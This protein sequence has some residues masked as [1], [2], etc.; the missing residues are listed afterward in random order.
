MTVTSPRVSLSPEL[1]LVLCPELRA[2]PLMLVPLADFWSMIA[3]FPFLND[4][5]AW[6]LEM[7]ELSITKWATPSFLPMMRLLPYC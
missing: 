5:M 7:L 1:I 3:K 4:R 2:V 6:L